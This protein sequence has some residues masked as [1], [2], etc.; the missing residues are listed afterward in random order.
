MQ[1]VC[2]YIY[3]RDRSALSFCPSKQANLPP[4]IRLPSAS[5]RAGLLVFLFGFGHGYPRRLQGFRSLDTVARINN[6]HAPDQ[7]LR[8]FGYSAPVFLVELVLSVPHS[9]QADISFSAEWTISS[10]DDVDDD[11]QTPHIAFHVVFWTV[12]DDFGCHESFRSANRRQRIWIVDLLGITKVADLHIHVA[13]VHQ[14]NVLGLQITHSHALFV[15]VG[16]S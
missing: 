13:V 6:E 1:E 2:V 8:F 11:T 14:Q 12:L 9:F 5:S 16:K 15:T 3:W 4:S 7:I 10:E